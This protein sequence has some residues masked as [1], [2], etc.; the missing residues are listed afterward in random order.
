MFSAVGYVPKDYREYPTE[1][2]YLST[3]LPGK[4]PH[5][6]IIS[7]TSHVLALALFYCIKTTRF[8]LLCATVVEPIS[9]A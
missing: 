8:K 4:Q 9:S 6:L 2:Q 5:H 3:D 7:I 1:G